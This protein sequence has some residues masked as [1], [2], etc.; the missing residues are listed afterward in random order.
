MA[1]GRLA[2]VGRRRVIASARAFA[3]SSSVTAFAFAASSFRRR[4]RA[5]S[6]SLTSAAGS[7][8]RRASPTLR[9]PLAR[10]VFVEFPPRFRLDWGYESKAARPVFRR[11]GEGDVESMRRIVA[12]GCAA[13]LILA[14]AAC[15]FVR[16]PLRAAKVGD[17]LNAAFG[18]SPRLHWSAPQAATF[19]LFPWP[20]LRVVDARLNDAYGVNLLSAP[21]ARLDLSLVELMRGR[22]VPARAILVS[23]TVTLDI[24]RPPFAGAADGSAA[25]ASVA[26][27]LTPLASLSLSNGVVRIVSNKRGLDTLIENVRGRLDGL[28]IGNQLRFDLSA[29][30]RNAPI[31]ILGALGDPEAAAKGAPSPFAFALDSPIAKLAFSGALAVGDAP[32]A[33][34]DVTASVASIAALMARLNL[35]PPRILFSD[36]IAITAKVKATLD[37]ITLGDATLTSAGQTFDGALEIANPGGRPTVSG[38]LAADGVAL[39]PLLGPAERLYDPA[40][41]WSAKPFALA[42]PPA[43]DLDLR[44]SASRL[45]GYGRALSNAAASVIVNGGRLSANLIEAAAYDGRLDGEASVEWLGQ[46]LNIRARGELADADL[47]AVFAD[48][49]RPLATGRGGARF[50]VET[51]GASPAAAVAGLSGSASLEAADGGIVGV[52]LEEALRRSQRRPIDVAR[53]MRLGGTAFDT[54]G[55][56]FVL[57]NGRA[58]VERGAMTS[59]GVGAELEGLV[60]LVAQRWDLRLNAVQ[61]DAAGE[62]SQNAAHL[63][64]DIDGPWSAPTIRAIGDAGGSPASGEEATPPSH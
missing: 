53:D 59:R 56:S 49:G 62:E 16:W 48:F 35:E 52:N 9:P 7:W 57:D 64:L 26:G 47:G 30:W 1:P 10:F 29:V 51:S 33:E 14:L 12:W 34:G 18:A 63:T 28:T 60:D 27:A 32:S 31:A 11:R 8:R 38:T 61:T 45:D 39:A 15:G 21:S 41:G 22:I 6:A 20:S 43:F 36:D 24:D 46:D 23:P 2:I 4:A 50:A 44:L 25:P 13:A 40:D 55:V 5:E 54:L 37:A 42:A 3:F 17:S 58:R 19:S